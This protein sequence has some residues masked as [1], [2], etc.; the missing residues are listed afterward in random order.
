MKTIVVDPSLCIQCTNCQIACKDEHCDND[1]SPVA[2]AQSE[3]QFWVQ[4]REQQV[5]SGSRMRL[6]RVPV[7]C[8]QCADAPCM[9]AAAE[10]GVPEA[11]YRRED[12]IVI[13]DPEKSRGVRA[14]KDACPYG[15]V[16][17][18][19]ALDI[20]QK[21]TQCAHLLD[22][23]WEAPRCVTACPRDAL[24]YV[25][26]ADLEP[27]K[28]YAPLE[29]LNPEFGM[30]PTVAY[31]NLPRPFVAGEVYAPAENRCLNRAQVTLV[32]EV[33]GER[34]STETDF[35]GEF[36]IEC[37]SDGFYALELDAEGFDR[38]VIT[39][40]KVR[41]GLNAGSIRLCKTPC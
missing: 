30:H 4:I 19:D 41:G 2:A 10:A 23:G 27:A 29:R 3:G 13:I 26:V 33:T 12:G 14:I 15:C 24:R 5:A 40:L 38:K 17:W 31:V 36:R 1:W 22:A 35:F 25:D 11:V 28:L 7:M 8:Q 18:N 16:Y 37:A 6:N 34:R 20:P 21:C 9:A 39:H 32:N